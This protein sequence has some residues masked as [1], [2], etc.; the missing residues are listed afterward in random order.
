MLQ[1][2]KSEGEEGN[3]KLMSWFSRIW[4]SEKTPPAELSPT[5]DENAP[6]KAEEADEVL[7]ENNRSLLMQLITANGLSKGMDLHR[8]T[9]PTFI[10]EPRSLLEKVG[11]VLVHPEILSSMAHIP[12]SEGRMIAAARWYLSAYHKRTRGVKKPFNPIL[13]E[14]FRCSYSASSDGTPAS[15]D[16]CFTWTAEQVN[17]HP[18]VSAFFARNRSG[19]VIVLGH[20]A[21]QSRFLGNS[22]AAVGKGGFRVFLPEFNEVY[23]FTWPTAY[24]RGIIFGTLLMELGGPVVIRCPASGFS[25]NLEFMV[26]GYFSG[27]RDGVSG[28][29]FTGKGD[30]TDQLYELDG[31]WVKEVRIKNLRTQEEEVLLNYHAVPM[32]TCT[33]DD[34]DPLASR[35]NFSRVLW[36]GLVDAVSKNDHTAATKVKTQIEEAQRKL[37]ADREANKEVWRPQFFNRTMTK[38]DDA[39]LEFLAKEV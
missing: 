29:I 38:D 24:A 3:I 22:V 18:P 14:I 34:A 28:R 20:Y 12:T 25:C 33:V 1:G 10:L 13:G 30:K 11:D 19:N 39:N 7:P 21:P 9:F 26:K 27:K 17:H 2:Q 16:N 32:G 37:R 6:I 35:E 36:S 8:I 4:K 31:T 5:E 15:D 23:Y